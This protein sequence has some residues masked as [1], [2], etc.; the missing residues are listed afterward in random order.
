M[1]LYWKVFTINALVLSVA[2]IALAVG[3]VTVSRPTAASE[4]SVLG[5]GLAVMLLA[6]ALLLRSSLNPIDRI[7][8]D[9][10]RLDP[11]YP[12]ARVTASSSEPGRR[13]ADTVNDVLERL[14]NERA[15]SHAKT[16]AAQEAERQRIAQE[17]HDEVGQHLTVVLLGLKKLEHDLPVGFGD[18]VALLRDSVREGLDDVRRVVY[19][20]RP[21]VL[22]DLGLANA[23]AALTND[24]ER[25]HRSTLKRTIA[26]G[27]PT[28][29]HETELVIYRIG[30]EALTNAARHADA[31]HV[32]VSLIHEDAEIVLTVADDGRGFEPAE[33]G[34]SGDGIRGMYDRAMVVGGDL[35][36][37]SSPGNGTTLRLVVPLQPQSGT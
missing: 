6:N 1:R 33:R 9:M 24:F 21:S 25:H 31:R 35:T 28:L 18:E 27:L 30:Q 34:R 32:E 23:L 16:L 11:T 36:I 12:K 19:Q 4:L 7:I 3:P 17:L 10:S 26:P 15:S 13:L 29:P 14:A 2:T 8:T 22:A 20:L 37:I 5:T